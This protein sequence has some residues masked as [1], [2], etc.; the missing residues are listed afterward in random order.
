MANELQ[1]KYFDW[2]YARVM[3][4]KYSYRKLLRRLNEIPFT[5]ILPMDE[6]RKADGLYLR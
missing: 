6:N 3:G 4:D 5:N 1:E 2:I